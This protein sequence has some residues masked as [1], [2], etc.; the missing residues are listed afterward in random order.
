MHAQWA[1]LLCI[2]LVCGMRACVSC[3]LGI[4]VIGERAGIRDMP[5]NGANCVGNNYNDGEIK[6]RDNDSVLKLT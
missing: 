2:K 5:F 4:S 3:S 6:T 1:V